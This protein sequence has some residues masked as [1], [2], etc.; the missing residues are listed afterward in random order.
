MG[1]KI[2]KIVGVLLV[3][4]IVVL[5]A[6]PFF[7]EAKIGEIIKSNVNQNVNATLD[8]SEA[9]LSLV[10]SFPN[11]EVDFKDVVLLNKAPFEGD[12]LFKASSLD[13]TMGI[14]QLFKSEGDAIAINNINLDGAFINVVVD[15][16]ENASYD[17]A[18][19]SEPTAA[20]EESSSTDGFNLDLQS[21]EI[22]NTRIYYT[23][24]ST[25]IAFKL[26]DFQH[27]GTGD[28]SLAT[29]E[30]DTHTDAFISL[31]MDSV[32]Y[33]NKNKIKLDAL[34]GIDL[35]ENKYS[36][37]KNEALINQLP[38]VFDGFIKLNETSQ[39]I[40]LTFKTPSSDF[41]NFLGLIPEIYSKDIENVTTTGDFA[42]NGNFNGIVDETHIPKFHVD[43]KS[44]N[45]S[46]KYPD[47]PKAVSNVFFDIQLNNKTGIVEDTYVDVNKASF[48]IDEDKFNLTSHITELMGNTKVKAHIDGAMNLANISKAY[49]VP[50]EYD[51]K[52]LLK[53][54]ITTAFDMQSVEKEQYEKTSTTGDLSVTNFEYNS[55]ELANPVKFNAARL[56]FNPKT[57][58][59]NQLNGTTGT[60]DFDATGTI[61]NLLGF[62][63]NDEKVEGNFNLK[64]NSFALSDFMVAE[65]EVPATT[66]DSKS[67]SGGA[68]QEEKIKIPSFLDATIN[69]DAKKVL[70]D[71]IVL[72]DVKGVL[73]IKDETAT[74]SNMTAGMFGGKIGFN[75][76]VSTK[77][78]TPTFNMKLDLN[79]LGIQ[80]TFASVD[81][82][83][84]IAPIAKMLNG[85][86]TS[87]IS[88]SGNLTD[89]LMPNLLSLS[90]DMFADLM[91]EEVNTEE[92]PVLNSLVSN[93]NFIDLKQLNLKDLKTSLSFKDGIVV[94]K[95]FTL[96]YKDIAIN[97]DGSHSF[98]QKLNYKATLQ[99]PAK[100][101][102]S[103]ITKLIAKIDDPS[104]AD[105]TI[106]VVANIGGLYNSPTVTTDMTSGVKQLT[107]KLI[108]VEKQKLIAKGTDKAK[109]LIGGLISG[110]KTT[111]DSTSQKSTDT[112]TAAKDILGGIL[113][114][115]KDTASTT[116][117]KKDSTPVKTEEAV[118]E[119]AKDILGGLFGKKKNDSTN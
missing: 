102:G 119:K 118:K 37:L 81:L 82:F 65:T 4:I 75:G 27:R 91:T 17:I 56:T 83:K 2:L 61:N 101:L 67:T 20:D 25:G 112:K 40:D 57:V 76:D 107:T 50:A 54:D 26:D 49:P 43:L 7:L 84:A 51:L 32:N 113:P 55:E 80:E 21:Y 38:L 12:T 34:I 47:L 52:G 78:E 13:L 97:V 92:A 94:V 39:E 96:N 117:V 71:D 90:G 22:T 3:L 29:S 35:N 93:L 9:N 85:K 108:E 64:S 59:L 114:T 48:M 88:L 106:P 73:K 116:S 60:T 1:K 110:N 72:S 74:L 89:D 70:Y 103:D 6:A 105:L 66:N 10:S 41:K 36:F 53:A 19:P 8:F 111:T 5:I 31:E 16:E 28:L 44:D 100:Y 109:D 115:K 23:D 24:N 87:D 63:F 14:M 104:L 42:V 86:L 45:A 18:K 95:P 69:A 33:L 62:M 68:V 30:L 98:D 46:F 79:Q 58:T 11:A 15:K 77:N 99:V